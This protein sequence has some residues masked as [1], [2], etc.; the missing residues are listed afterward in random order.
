MTGCTS[1]TI[2]ENISPSLNGR[3]LIATVSQT[4][5][6]DEPTT[7]P[8]P[9]SKSTLKDEAVKPQPEDMKLKQE[10]SVTPPPVTKPGPQLIGHLPRAEEQALKTFAEIPANLY[11]YGTLGRSREALES[12]TCDCYYEHGSLP[13]FFS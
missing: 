9:E 1:P 6:E 7:S 10:A 5:M 8:R 13:V 12:M 4:K 11:Q 3:E 2:M